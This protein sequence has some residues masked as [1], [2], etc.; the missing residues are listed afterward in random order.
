MREAGSQGRLAL[1]LLGLF[2]VEALLL[3][4][5]GHLGITG[6]EV[7]VL[8]G[9]EAALRLADGQVQ[10]VDFLTPLGVLAFEPIA[11]FLRAGFGISTAYMAATL[12]VAAF[13]LPVL[14]W[15]SERLGPLAILFCLA[16]LTMVTAIV[17]GG[18]QATTSMSMYYNRWG[19]AAAF[20]II[21]IVMLP[22]R[23]AQRERLDGVVLGLML[24]YLLLLKVTFF[25]M[26]AAF[27]AVALLINRAW[28]MLVVAILT[29]AV[30]C[31]LASLYFGFGLWQ[32]YFH[33]VMFVLVNNVRPKPG[34]DFATTLAAPAFMPATICLLAAIVGLRRVGYQR[35]G[36][37][38]FLAAPALVYITYQN[39]GNDTKWLLPL[40]VLCLIW[41]GK[42]ADTKV[43]SASGKQYFLVVGVAAL[44]LIAPSFLNMLVSPVRN[45][46]V[47]PSKY[48]AV[49]KDPRHAGLI[50]ERKRSYAPDVMRS[51]AGVDDPQ[52]SDEPLEEDVVFAGVEMAGCTLKTGYFGMMQTLGAELI[53][54]GYGAALIAY[55]DVANPLPMMTDMPRLAYG[56][57]WYYGGTRDAAGADVVV[58]PKC[59]ISEATR[60][61]YVEAL[62]ES[63]TEWRLSDDLVHVWVFKR[64]N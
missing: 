63:E 25:L 35:E 17:Y 55:V 53:E 3:L 24:G 13:F 54:A 19:W 50:I 51:V 4:V 12:L 44:A 52:P 33:D 56:S 29:G 64:Q 30:I 14:I 42:L 39:W 46:L 7:D 60:R 62:N 20:V 32:A 2:V 10:H 8:H 41:S 23:N 5:P 47:D 18:N 61:A 15:I 48:V 21:L 37:L 58:V 27:V 22:E 34:N 57:P 1:V 49:V 11:I 6:H 36:L 28:R 9:A 31:L 59:P 45:A 38:L 43:G 26:M 40:G 16:S